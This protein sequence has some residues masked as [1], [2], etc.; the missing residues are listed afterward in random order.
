[1]GMYNEFKPL[2]PIY[3]SYCGKKH[4]SIQSTALGDSLKYY[5]PGDKLEFLK[6]MEEEGNG[7]FIIEDI[8]CSCHEAM[9][10]GVLSFFYILTSNYNYVS[11]F[12]SKRD[13]EDYIETLGYNLEDFVFIGY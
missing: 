8:M 4:E 1:M 6:W 12:P 7:N 2:K 11:C 10:A 3:C 5:E 13:T 9:D